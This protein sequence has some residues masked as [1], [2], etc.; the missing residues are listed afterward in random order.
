MNCVQRSTRRAARLTLVLWVLLLS[1]PALSQRPSELPRPPTNADIRLIIDISGSMKRNDPADLR[2][3]A[4]DLL[5]RILPDGS[6]AGIWTFGRQVNMLVP[7]RKVDDS[8]R[9]EARRQAEQINATGLFTN[10]G[11]ALENAISVPS[12]ADAGRGHLILLT[13]GMVDIDRD[14]AK[15]LQERGR[16]QND[17]LARIQARG[18]TL[19]TIALSAN[20][21]AGLMKKL[22]QATDGSHTVADNAD[23]LMMAFIKAFDASAPADQLPIGDGNAFLVD[24]SVEELTALIFRRQSEKPTQLV[25]PDGTIYL[26]DKQD[27]D[28]QWYQTDQYDLMTVKHPLEGEWKVLADIA[29]ESRVTVISNLGLRLRP[30]PINVLQGAALTAEFAV[31]EGNAAI[32]DPQFLALLSARAT[33]IRRVERADMPVWTDELP[34]GRI[35]ERG[36]FAISLPSLDEAGDYR[37][38]LEVNGQTFQRRISHPL[39]VSP[40][41]SLESTELTDS[42]GQIGF[43]LRV[44][45]HLVD[46]APERVQVVASVLG[47]DRRKQVR[48]LQ[49]DSQGYWQAVITPRP[50][51]DHLL[52]AKVTGQNTAGEPFQYDLGPQVLGLNADGLFAVPDDEEPEAPPVVATPPS[53]P[54]VSEP[55]PLPPEQRDDGIPVW[56]WAVLLV[57][58]GGVTLGLVYLIGRRRKSAP[59]SENPPEAASPSE[60]ESFAMADTD[61]M[62]MDWDAEPKLDEFDVEE[63][64]PEEEPGMEDLDSEPS[65]ETPEPEPM[66]MDPPPELVDPVADPV[67]TPTLPAEDGYEMDDIESD[68]VAWATADAT[69]GE[70][71]D[72]AAQMRKAQ[73]LDL[74]G[75]ELDDAITNLIDELDGEPDDMDD[76]IQNPMPDDIDPLTGLK[77]N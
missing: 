68:I 65:M 35:P 64:V 41:F 23:A 40:P 17:V 6:H 37:L 27:A 11:S 9:D 34:A 39:Q 28:I 33:L 60:E 50:N 46:F 36:I 31:T 71:E 59:S 75:D 67:E 70:K 72:F 7:F 12:P 16:I 74:E 18:M 15:N 77:R 76:S 63:A 22:A 44:V 51:G 30:L 29:P 66:V 21:D 4:V 45:P 56:L 26:A 32:T 58:G 73:G 48:P 42:Q 13:D 1:L 14:P 2:K 47:P 61:L 55:E 43:E 25:S 53:P 10:I 49:W 69:P 54:E 62:K 8:W 57:A 24:S 38:D 20:A 3:P 52:T 19:H 5:V